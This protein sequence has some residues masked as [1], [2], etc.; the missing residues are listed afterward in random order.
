[1]M[2]DSRV[3]SVD[4]LAAKQLLA[5]LALEYTDDMEDVVAQHFARHRRSCSTWAA[6]RVHSNVLRKLEDGSAIY[7]QRECD[8]WTDGFRFA[9]QQL[10]SV[11][12]EE[13]LETTPVE[14]WTKGQYLRAMVRQ[15]RNS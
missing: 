9:E 15:A 1:M 5:G 10:M 11:D 14:T 12:P 6:E 4:R 8:K 2:D 13:L 3:W 7:F